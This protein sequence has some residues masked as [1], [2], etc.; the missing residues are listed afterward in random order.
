MC[1]GSPIFDLS[2]IL[3]SGA[4]E[5]NLNKFDDYLE[6][7]HNSLTNTLK[8]F[9]LKA[10]IVYSL[11]MFKEEW[12]KYCKFGFPLA[13]GIWKL[14]LIDQNELP[15]FSKNIDDVTM[16]IAECFEEDYKNRIREL[17]FHL[18]SNGFI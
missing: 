4:S 2:Y 3:Y 11:K 1:H 5:D 7:Y 8:E 10:E 12:K 6:I 9:D 18:N 15:D 16:K 14:K 13:L 17:V